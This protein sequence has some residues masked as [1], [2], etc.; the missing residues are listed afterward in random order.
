MS[1]FSAKDV[2]DLRRTTG[3][4]MMDAKRAL[5]ETGGDPAAATKLLLEKG[6]ADARKRTGRVAEQGTIGHYLHIQAERPVIGVIV[7][8]TSETDFVAK[9]PEFQATARDL[10]MHIAAAKPQWVRVEEV[11][12]E[13]IEAEKEIFM[14]QARNEGKSDAII[15][16]IIPGKVKSFLKEKVLYE[17]PFIRPEQFEGTVGQMVEA[18]AGKMGENISVRRFSR[19]GVGEEEA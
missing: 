7:E 15:E 11:P 2:A 14:A 1:D 10:A 3:A 8:L 18:M 19:I 5:E 16:K 13:A 6:I 9:S 12:E 4:G 17:Q